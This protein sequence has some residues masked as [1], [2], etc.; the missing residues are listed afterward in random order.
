MVVGL[1]FIISKSFE[2]FIYNRSARK[3][4]FLFI[5]GLLIVYS[6]VSC[7]NEIA[8]NICDFEWFECWWCDECIC[9]SKYL[10]LISLFTLN[11]TPIFNFFFFLFYSSSSSKSVVLSVLLLYKN[12]SNNNICIFSLYI[13]CQN[14]FLFSFA[15]I[16]MKK[17]MRERRKKNMINRYGFSIIFNHF[18]A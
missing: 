3:R 8:I 7:S 16:K 12:E 5:F 14:H 2:V 17:M 4:L 13:W 10:C 11:R 9:K 1:Y 15:A 6:F 18:G